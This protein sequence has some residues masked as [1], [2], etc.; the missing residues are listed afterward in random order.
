MSAAALAGPTHWPRACGAGPAAPRPLLR[1]RQAFGCLSAI[2]FG[3]AD[4]PAQPTDWDAACCLSISPSNFEEAAPSVGG[5]DTSRV[6]QFYQTV[7]TRGLPA[8]L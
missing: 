5:T 6:N 7:R 3:R 2:G 4:A 1:W 8:G